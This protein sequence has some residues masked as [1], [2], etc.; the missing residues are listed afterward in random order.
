MVVITCA[1]TEVL[2]DLQHSWPRA[3][4]CKLGRQRPER[5]PRVH[6]RSR[7]ARLKNP[8]L[9]PLRPK[10]PLPPLQAAV[11]R[12]AVRAA[13]LRLQNA[14]LLSG[15]TSHLQIKLTERGFR[16]KLQFALRS[17]TICGPAGASRA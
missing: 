1:G 15:R 7:S 14:H 8:S 2:A 10:G 4:G 3:A 17:E 16:Q 12:L 5:S 9:Q 6:A 13:P 11:S